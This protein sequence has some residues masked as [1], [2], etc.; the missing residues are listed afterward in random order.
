MPGLDAWGC[1]VGRVTGLDAWGCVVGR[2]T[3]KAS[4]PCDPVGGDAGVCVTV[5]TVEAGRNG[6]GV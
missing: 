6:A 5:P 4:D 2:G 1:V 3:G